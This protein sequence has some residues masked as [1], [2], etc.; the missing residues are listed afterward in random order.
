MSNNARPKELWETLYKSNNIH[1]DIAKIYPS[2]F[3]F[4]LT[5]HFDKSPKPFE[6][7]KCVNATVIAYLKGKQEKAANQSHLLQH[8]GAHYVK[9]G[10]AA[11][12]LEY[13]LRQISK[14]ALAETVLHELT[15]K[16]FDT[17]A[18]RGLNVYNNTAFNTGPHNPLAFIAELSKA[19]SLAANDI[20]ELP[21]KDENEKETSVRAANF[22]K[23]ENEMRKDG[24]KTLAA[25]HALEK[26]A[27]AFRETWEQH[28]T[29]LF[30]KGRYHHD[31]G[32]YASDATRAFHKIIAQIDLQIPESLAGTAIENIRTLPKGD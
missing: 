26:A 21:H 31:K 24:N 4:D 15:A 28:S 8:S 14:S 29:K 16:F 1:A 13:S 27:S 2:E 20:L 30:S 10:I 3:Y 22:V 11:K 25:H 9:A 17:D 32:G 12:Q 18:Q 7:I 6:L 5:T 19:L 23:K